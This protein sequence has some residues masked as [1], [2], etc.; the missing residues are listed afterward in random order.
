MILLV[1][2]YHLLNKNTEKAR[3]FKLRQDQYKFHV[4]LPPIFYKAIEA[5][6]LRYPIKEIFPT[7][8]KT[9]YLTLFEKS[10]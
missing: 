7:V 10:I 9:F 1:I 5:Y 8:G 3:L 6:P 2:I 4:P